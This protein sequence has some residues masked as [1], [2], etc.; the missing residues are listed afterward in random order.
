MAYYIDTFP[1]REIYIKGK[2]HLYFGGTAYLGLQT[3]PTFQEIFIKNVHAYGTAYGASR[4]SNVRL[5]IYGEAEAYL[6]Q[7]VG[8]E[9]CTTLSSGYLA[10]QFVMQHFDGPQYRLFH[11]PNTHTALQTPQTSC[12]STYTAMKIA[13]MEHLLDPGESIPVVL[14]DSIDF[15]GS[16]YPEFEALKTLPL[17]Q[18]I[19]VVDDSH[20]IGIIG[21]NGRG[22]FQMLKA[23]QP[24]ELIVSCSL[25]KGF[26]VQAG[27][28]FGANKRITKLTDSEFFGGASPAT[29]AAM[30][31]LLQAEKICTKKRIIL[32]DRIAMFLKK[33]NNANKFHWMQGHPAFSYGNQEL[34]EHLEQQ[35]IIVSNFSYPN[36][37]ASI[38]GRIVIGAGHKK[39]DLQKLISAVNAHI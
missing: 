5:S 10:G 37:V 28:V 32:Q 27:A 1:G 38:M 6:A 23:L 2:P 39:E 19:L 18:I 3:D 9:A 21:D 33:T 8:S 22:V 13:L 34:S 15:S 35:G 29:P 7:L 16:N 17:D 14:M 20:G 26:G 24:K 31:T 25:G 4:N 11:A 12:Y 30:A 36:E